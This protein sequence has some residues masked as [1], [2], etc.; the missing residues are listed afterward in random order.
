MLQSDERKSSPSTSSDIRNKIKQLLQ[1][2]R[3]AV[4][5]ATPIGMSG[6]EAREMLARINEIAE[7]LERLPEVSRRVPSRENFSHGNC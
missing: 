4:S 2:Q 5:R 1:H 7:L 3:F 6:D